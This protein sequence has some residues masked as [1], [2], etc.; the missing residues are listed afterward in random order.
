[1]IKV[2]F[3]LIKPRMVV[4]NVAVAGAVFIFA[5]SNVVNWQAFW[6][7]VT[8]LACVVAAACVFNNYADRHIDARMERTKNRG[9]ASGKVE[10]GHALVFGAVLFVLGVILLFQTNLLALGA[11]LVG[12]V[13][14]VFVYTLL[15]PKSGYALYVG[16]VAGAT[17]PLVGYAAGAGTIDLMALALFAVLFLWQIPHFLAIARY[18]FDEYTAGGVP[19]LVE[20]PRDEKEKHQAR[21]IFYFSLVFLLLFCVVLLVARVALVA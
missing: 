3:N 14:Y 17:P 5:S 19:L 13:T 6:F 8:G 21:K 7:M 9:L 2:Y 16:A 10:P 12:F 15:K 1:M 18:R 20:S 11:A 4:M